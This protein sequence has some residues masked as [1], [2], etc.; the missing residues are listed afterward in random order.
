MAD[1]SYVLQSVVFGKSEKKTT[2]AKYF[3]DLT[4]A[5]GLATAF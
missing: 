5:L 4:D 3:S 1:R 2:R